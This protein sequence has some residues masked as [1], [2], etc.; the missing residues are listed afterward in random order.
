MP[1]RRLH[2]HDA[3]E[4]AL[5]AL[6]SVVAPSPDPMLIKLTRS[7]AR[8]AARASWAEANKTAPALPTQP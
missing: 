8:Q 6:L 3:D 4:A 2:R 5:K 7:L 1:G